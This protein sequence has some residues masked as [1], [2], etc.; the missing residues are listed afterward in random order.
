MFPAS[1][2]TNS[3]IAK[4]GEWQTLLQCMQHVW[5]V[6]VKIIK[7]ITITAGIQDAVIS[8]EILPA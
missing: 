6:T 3:G 1:H 8:K 2:F 4:L 7:I 5:L